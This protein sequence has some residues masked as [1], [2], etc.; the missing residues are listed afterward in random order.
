MSFDL[1]FCRPNAPLPSVAALKQYFA[2]LP[3]FNVQDTADDGVQFWYQ[4]ESTGVYCDFSYSPLDAVEAEGC[5]SSGISFNLNFVRPS[6]FAY[7]TMPLVEAFCK[8]FDLVVEDPQAETIGPPNANDLIASWRNSNA[9]ATSAVLAQ[10]EA[11]THYLPEPTATQWW[12]YMSVF[13]T[14]QTTVT[15]DLYIPQPFI[16]LNPAKQLFTMTLW[17]DGIAQFFPSCDYVFV[18]RDKKQLFGSKKEQGL[19]SYQNVMSALKPFLDQFEVGDLRLKYLRPENTA[20][21]ASL[22]KKLHLEPIEL[23]QHTRMGADSF[24][25]VPQPQ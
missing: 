18:Q 25:D 16:I 6:F 24:H 4:N 5:G 13:P 12:R 21:V 2:S 19:V 22:I 7:E 1:Y 23:S 8:Q 17:P 14:L 15:E 3:H 9:N 20:N 11:E 10:T